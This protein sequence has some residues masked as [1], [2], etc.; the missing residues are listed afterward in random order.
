[1]EGTTIKLNKEERHRLLEV[2]HNLK[3]KYEPKTSFCAFVYADIIQALE[4]DSLTI[5]HLKKVH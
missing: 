4:N 1:M 2:L 3:D 5:E